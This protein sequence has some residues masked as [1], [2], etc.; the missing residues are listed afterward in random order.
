M[1]SGSGRVGG[2]RGVGEA[3]HVDLV[4][5]GE[6]HAGEPRSRAP[7]HDQARRAGVGAA[8]LQFVLGAQAVENPNACAKASARTRSGFSNS[9]Q[10]MSA[11]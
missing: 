10:A 6:R 2:A 9:S 4:L 11:P 7:A 8:Q 3:Q 5:C 1:L